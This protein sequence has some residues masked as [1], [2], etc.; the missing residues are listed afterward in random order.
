MRNQGKSGASV[1]DC[2]QNFVS[3]GIGIEPNDLGWGMSKRDELAEKYANER[4][5]A[6]GDIVNQMHWSD[7]YLGFKAGWDARDAEVKR[8]REALKYYADM[9]HSLCIT[10]RNALAETEAGE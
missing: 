7:C 9:D 8:L 3:Q 10:A 6:Q 1:G 2:P 5:E 4:Y